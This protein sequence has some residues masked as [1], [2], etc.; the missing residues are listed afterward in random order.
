MRNWVGDRDIV[1]LI[2]EIIK[3]A[4]EMVGSG[5]WKKIKESFGKP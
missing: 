2:Q 5:L 3:V 4:D 1:Q